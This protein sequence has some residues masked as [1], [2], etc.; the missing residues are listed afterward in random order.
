MKFLSAYTAATSNIAREGTLPDADAEAYLSVLSSE[1]GGPH[2][3]VYWQDA[4][5]KIAHSACVVGV[6]LNLQIAKQVAENV[7]AI[8]CVAVD[9]KR[10]YSDFEMLVLVDE[11]M[12]GRPLTED[13]GLKPA[14]Y[15]GEYFQRREWS[16]SENFHWIKGYRGIHGLTLFIQEIP[17]PLTQPSAACVNIPLGYHCGRH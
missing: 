1:V 8:L 3:A 10:A 13:L 9:P 17:N 7:N 5:K 4:V 6:F 15:D 11:L 16:Q 12:A 2:F 14:D